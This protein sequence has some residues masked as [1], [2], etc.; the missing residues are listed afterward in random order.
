MVMCAPKPKMTVEEREKA[1]QESLFIQR[2]KDG[3]GK[4]VRELDGVRSWCD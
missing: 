2:C 4:V 1:I 3:G